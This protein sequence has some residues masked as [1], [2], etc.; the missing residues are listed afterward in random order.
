MCTSP[1]S[2]M[3]NFHSIRRA[4][5]K[6]AAETLEKANKITMSDDPEKRDRFT[7]PPVTLS[8]DFY[9]VLVS[10]RFE[11]KTAKPLNHRDYEAALMAIDKDWRLED[12]LKRYRPPIEDP[13]AVPG[14]SGDQSS[15]PTGT[16]AGTSTRAGTGKGKGKLRE[17]MPKDDPVARQQA[18]PTKA[19]RESE[20]ESARHT[21]TEGSNTK[22]R[23]KKK[24][25]IYHKTDGGTWY[26]RR[27]DGSYET[28]R[29]ERKKGSGV[30]PE[31]EREM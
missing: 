2:R 8:R 13:S 12:Y 22:G 23:G 19:E 10:G 4:T 11:A 5:E 30:M 28:Y 27:E 16:A 18:V 1:T 17:I 14:G 6:Q 24:P 26:V 29:A 3:T 31:S 9:D 15:I 25:S 21:E 20:I 7:R